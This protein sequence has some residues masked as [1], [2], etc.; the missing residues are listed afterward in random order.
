MDWIVEPERRLPVIAETEVLV[1]GGG[2]AGVAAAVAAARQGARVLLIERYGFLGGLVTGGLV[3]T[4][5]PLDNGFNRELAERLVTQ[6]AYAPLATPGAE[7][8]ALRMRAMDPEMVKHELVAML[9]EAGVRVLYH[10]LIVGACRTDDR[11]AGI[12][13]ENKAGR[14]AI[15]AQVVIDAT[16]DADVAALA[17]A[18]V[19]AVRK[20]ITLM[21]NMADVNVARALERIGNWSNLKAIVREAVE[22]GELAFDLGTGLEWGAPGIHAEALIPSGE[23]NV[24][25]GN[26]RGVDPLDPVQLSEAEVVTREHVMRLWRFLRASVPG[27]EHSRI[28]YTAQCSGSGRAGRFWVRRR[29]TC[30]RY[31]IPAF[32]T[33]SPSPTPR[34]ACGCRTG[35]SSRRAWSSSWWRAAASRRTKSPWDSCASSRSARRR[36][37]RRGS[38]R[39]S[40]RSRPPLPGS[41]TSPSC[42]GR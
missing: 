22:R 5:P 18:P 31:G 26:L 34:R 16:G 24:W 14:Q 36:A 3:I 35:R 8:I 27:F 29:R 10:T 17:Q 9:R 37:R 13:I 2:F 23:I 1:C 33:P 32:R 19:R 41:W 40:R 25:S 4:T 15:R 38:R 6:R 7:M 30:S 11:I 39:P 21:F 28:E 20:P 42:S 12:L